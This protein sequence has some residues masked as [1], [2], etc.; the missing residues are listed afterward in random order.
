MLRP[1]HRNRPVAPA[2]APTSGKAGASG[3]TGRRFPSPPAPQTPASPQSPQAPSAPA[4]QQKPDVSGAVAKAVRSS[5]G[6]DRL[7]LR[8]GNRPVLEFQARATLP[9]GVP[10]VYRRG[11]YIARVMTPGGRWLPT[12][13]RPSTCIITVSGRRGR[14]P[15]LKVDSRISGTWEM[16]RDGWNSSCGGDLAHPA[17]IPVRGMW[18]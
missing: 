6:A 3:G 16:A 18:I 15:S 14:R 17:P 13:S 12:I 9:A 1:V 8:D 11:G 7:T 5:R 4:P 2:R 10:E